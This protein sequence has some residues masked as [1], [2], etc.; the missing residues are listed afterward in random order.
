MALGQESLFVVS[1][2]VFWVV[3]TKEQHITRVYEWKTKHEHF[4]YWKKEDAD[5][6][7]MR[8][9]QNVIWQMTIEDAEVEKKTN[10]ETGEVEVLVLV[11]VVTKQVTP[12]MP[13]EA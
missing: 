4:R 1:G 13:E 5:E 12:T 8:K 3:M 11:E 2:R 10:E 6:D 7:V 9:H